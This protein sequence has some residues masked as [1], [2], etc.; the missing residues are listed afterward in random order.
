MKKIGIMGGTFSPIHLGHLMLAENAY[1]FMDL[2]EIWFI[3]SADPPHRSG[4]IVMSYAHRSR[5]TELA[6]A[7]VPYFI[8]S[9]FEASRK[10][11]S[12]TA[13]TLRL[14]RGL[15]P[16]NIFYF[17]MG[18]DSL[19]QLEDWYEPE[20]VMS[21][22]ILLVAAR[23]RH[24]KEELHRQIRYL[25]DKYEARIYLMHMP[26]MDLSSA[27]IRERIKNHQSIRFLVPE[28]VRSYIICHHL[29]EEGADEN[30]IH[31]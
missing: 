1:D 7:P 17:V 23:D 8:K 13:E 16:E 21:Q 15:Y 29:Y 9:D 14:L 3:P 26:E 25:E 20:R 30:E 27:L 19:F 5:M 12:Y 24:S 4:Q 28:E 2:D 11:P 18:A 10:G 6:I 31:H 22:A